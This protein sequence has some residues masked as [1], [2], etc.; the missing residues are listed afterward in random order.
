MAYG[1]KAS[2][3]D[4]LNL[5]LHFKNNTMRFNVVYNYIFQKLQAIERLWLTNLPIDR[6]IKKIN[7]SINH[8]ISHLISN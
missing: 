6:L 7:Q 4:P 1:Q 3:C 2:S 5:Y 8:S